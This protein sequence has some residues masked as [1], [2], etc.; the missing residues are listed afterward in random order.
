MI[1]VQ[2]QSR[3]RESLT[4]NLYIQYSTTSITERYLQCRSGSRVIG[5]CSHIASVMWYLAFAIRTPQ[6]PRQHLNSHI[7]ILDNVCDCTD[8]SSHGDDSQALN[9]LL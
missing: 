5:C 8:P 2:I 6:H 3:H 9:S 7:E 1:K 4:Y